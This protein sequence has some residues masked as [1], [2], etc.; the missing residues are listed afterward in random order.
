MSFV[1]SCMARELHEGKNNDVHWGTAAQSQV[2]LGFKRGSWAELF[3]SCHLG[4]GAHQ[5]LKISSSKN[6]KTKCISTG[7]KIQVQ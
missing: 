5:S 1:C 2:D 7:S 4:G 3:C 6:V